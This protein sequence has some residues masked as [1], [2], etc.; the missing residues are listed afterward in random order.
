MACHRRK[1]AAAATTMIAIQTMACTPS[2]SA[3]AS[4]RTPAG[5]PSIGSPP[6]SARNSQR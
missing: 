4:A 6:R 1:A 3:P 5:T 2:T